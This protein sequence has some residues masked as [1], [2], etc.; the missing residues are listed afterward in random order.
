MRLRVLLLLLA[1]VYAT[2]SYGL[3]SAHPSPIQAVLLAVSG[4]ALLPL[5]ALVFRRLLNKPTQPFGG[6]S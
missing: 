5:W 1:L 2:G 4:T 6:N 3:S